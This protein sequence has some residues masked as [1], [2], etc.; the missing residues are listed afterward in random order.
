MKE[1]KLLN[2]SWMVQEVPS[3]LWVPFLVRT[4][5]WVVDLCPHWRLYWRQPIN[6]S[7]TSVFLYLFISLFLP[8][9]LSNIYKHILM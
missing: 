5:T 3:R 9:P 4:H 8:S 6:V 2:S 1:K 7:L